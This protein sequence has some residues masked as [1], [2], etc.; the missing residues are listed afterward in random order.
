MTT[1]IPANHPSS[2]SR[3][4]TVS[5]VN[6]ALIHPSVR[7]I[8]GVRVQRPPPPP[9]P[10]DSPWSRTNR[11]TLAPPSREP[12]ANTL[13][14]HSVE[15]EGRKAPLKEKIS[16]NLT[17]PR[18]MP[19]RIDAGST[20]A[21][22]PTRRQTESRTAGSRTI[23]VGSRIWGTS[24][25]T[26]WTIVDICHLLRLYVIHVS[27]VSNHKIVMSRAFASRPVLTLEIPRMF[28]VRARVP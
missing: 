18:A 20:D 7:G 4:P 1:G 24:G 13:H 8:G 12:A 11:P 25:T 14:T 10:L 22:S 16:P 27:P 23:H 17:L 28:A 15:E 21:D 19:T 9:L 2:P 26:R 5:S 3:I 6:T